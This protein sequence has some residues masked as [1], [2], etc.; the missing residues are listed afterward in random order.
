MPTLEELQKQIAALQSQVAA[1][2]NPIIY[3]NDTVTPRVNPALREGVEQYDY[4]KFAREN[5][6]QAREIVR[7]FVD[8]MLGAHRAPQ[9]PERDAAIN[10]DTE[11]VFNRVLYGRWGLHELKLADFAYLARKQPQWKVR[12]GTDIWESGIV[13]GKWSDLAAAAS[14]G[15][16]L[17]N[18]FLDS[19][20]NPDLAVYVEARLS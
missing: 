9:T 18:N 19:E 20:V 2:Q 3:P 5:P 12:W 11:R 8:Q 14:M 10:R 7:V 15:E 4:E 13:G 16:S 1:L 6:Q 17:R